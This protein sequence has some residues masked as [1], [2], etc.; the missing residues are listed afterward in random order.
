MPLKKLISNAKITIGH[1]L[2]LGDR[3]QLKVDWLALYRFNA[4]FE[5]RLDPAFLSLEVPA[6]Y[7]LDRPKHW[8]FLSK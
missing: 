1:R 6:K 8:F 4:A 2:P 3:Y 5:N 7:V